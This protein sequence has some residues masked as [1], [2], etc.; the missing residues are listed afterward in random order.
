MAHDK[1]RDDGRFASRYEAHEFIEGVGALNMAT[2]SDV[3]TYVS[4][5]REDIDECPHR[6]ALH[7]LNELEDTGRL[8]SQSV[9]RAKVWSVVDDS[10]ALERRETDE[11]REQSDGT[12][13]PKDTGDTIQDTSADLEAVEFPDNRDRDA[14]ERAVLAA[15]DCIREHD[16]ATKGKIIREIMHDH[17]LGYDVTDT[18]EKLGSPSRYRGD[19]WQNVIT[20]GLKALDDIKEPDPDTSTWQYITD[21]AVD[22][23]HD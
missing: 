18:L 19:W 17:T 11:R 6:T 13:T 20:D 22:N 21:N 16:G 12:G 5:R 4:E 9:G 10:T 15:R 23:E 2:T 7:H 14:C 1:H 3:A 8:E